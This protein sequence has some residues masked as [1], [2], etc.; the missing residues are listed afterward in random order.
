M[1]FL[2]LVKKIDKFVATY[3]RTVFIVW[4]ILFLAVM[5]CLATS[6]QSNTVARAYEVESRLRKEMKWSGVSTEYQ[7][8]DVFKYTAIINDKFYTGLIKFEN[9]NITIL[10]KE[11]LK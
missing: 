8:N 5:I 3:P 2:R 1:K 10:T 4:M 11:K 6:C 7:G 9:G